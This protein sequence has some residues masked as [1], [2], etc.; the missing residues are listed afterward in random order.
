M[1]AC[2]FLILAV[3]GICFA[4]AADRQLVGRVVDANTGEPIA[5][6][7][8]TL[9]FYQGGQPAPEMTLLSDADGSFKVTNLP[10]S[11]YQVSCE[12]AGYLSA[13]QGSAAP[14]SADGNVVSTMELRLIAQAAVEGTVVDD[15]DIPAENTFI[16]LV[17]QQ[18]VNGRRQFQVA[19]GGGTD[20]TGYFRVFGLPAG[21]YYISIVPRLSGVRR[22]KPVAYPQLYYPIALDIA[23]AQPVDLKAGDEQQIKIRLPEPVPAFEVRGVVAT[24]ATGVGLSLIRQPSGQMFQ[25][26]A[27]ETSWD[28]KTKAFRISHVTPGIYLLTATAQDGKSPLQASAMVSVGS[29][30][31]TGIR[32]E[33][34]ETGLDGTVRSDAGGSPVRNFISLQ[35]ATQSNGAPVDG[36]GKFHIANLQPGTYR[37]SIQNG[38]QACIRSILEGG[39]DVR[40]GVTIAA[41]VSPEPI[42]V[43]LTSHCGSIDATVTSDSALPPNPSAILLR[44]AGD[45]FV[46]EKQGFVGGRSGDAPHFTLQG[47]A[48]GDYLLFVWP[49]EAQIEYTN[50]DFMK[51][52]ESYGQAITV[53]EDGKA[54]VTIDKVLPWPLPKN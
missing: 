3:L 22:A 15:K 6:A 1:K 38:P 28:P 7:H 47:I 20:E 18:V 17:H 31:V 2:R 13:N 4:Q 33:P 32:L 14:R 52:L 21:R 51:P 40:D 30:D 50:A 16:Q 44:K 39:R 12:K 45:E 19:G 27:G 36:D 34:T 23:T 24:A 8:V 46:L 41:G 10:E 5:H 11:G 54:T 49:A 43:V 53:T 29:A 35:S 9:R 26:P 42:D 25:Q 48:P 37:I